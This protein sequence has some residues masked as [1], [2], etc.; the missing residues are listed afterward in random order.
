MGLAVSKAKTN[1]QDDTM[2]DFRVA[3]YDIHMHPQTAN[4]PL[5]GLDRHVLT[6]GAISGLHCQIGI[7]HWCYFTSC[8][9]TWSEK[10]SLEK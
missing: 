8:G 7:L 10:S 2:V 4:I 5:Q 3:M 6:V 1:K 9:F